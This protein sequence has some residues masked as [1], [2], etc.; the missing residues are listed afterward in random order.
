[1]FKILNTGVRLSLRHRETI[2][3]FTKYNFS[4]F[5]AMNESDKI[6][7]HDY[8]MNF[9]PKSQVKAEYLTFNS[10][11][12]GKLNAN[13]MY[14]IYKQNKSFIF[15]KILMS[16][17][18]MATTI[19]ILIYLCNRWLQTE[20]QSYKIETKNKFALVCSAILLSILS[21]SLFMFLKNY[22]NRIWKYIT[23]IE[24]SRDLKTIHFKTSLNKSI[25][26]EL[27]NIYLYTNI[28]PSYYS[29]KNL[30][31]VRDT[32]II[33]IKDSIYIVSSEDSHIPSHDLF[34]ACLR[35]YD[36]KN[37]NNKA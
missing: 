11:K 18:F 4:K 8:V 2:I 9:N 29:V 34:A 15:V 20:Y 35:G 1:M 16:T 31:L 5:E 14:T 21:F 24:I 37:D 33:G 32:F 28:T 6:K 36:M 23:E 13:N 25:T 22:R 19:S 27:K 30:S 26:E 12:L 3:R 17:L 10:K 7:L